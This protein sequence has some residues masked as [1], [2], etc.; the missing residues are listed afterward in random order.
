MNNIQLYLI[1]KEG[2]TRM[3]AWRIHWGNVQMSSKKPIL[4][5]VGNISIEQ[6]IV[7]LNIASVSENGHQK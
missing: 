6:K 3:S 5:Y 4:N 1:K 7:L 2:H